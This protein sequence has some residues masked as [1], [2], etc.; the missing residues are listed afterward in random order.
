MRKR[1]ELAASGSCLNRAHPLEMIFTLRGIDE[2]APAAVRAW[3]DD[4]IRRGKNAASDPQIVEALAC[5]ET[6]ER[7]GRQWAEA[8]EDTTFERAVHLELIR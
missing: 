1:D 2:S 4:R 3:V 8:P 5:A 6:M 7:E